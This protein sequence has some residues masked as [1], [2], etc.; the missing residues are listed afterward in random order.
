M[1]AAD[2]IRCIMHD[3]TQA[4]QACMRHS[5][6]SCE[7]LRRVTNEVQFIKIANNFQIGI[8]ER[9]ELARC[10]HS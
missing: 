8:N 6:V 5:F 3:T 2:S 7:F 10:L 4:H 1:R 9:H